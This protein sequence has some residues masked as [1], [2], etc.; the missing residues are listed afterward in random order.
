MSR[1]LVRAGEM[2]VAW[3]GM[4]SSPLRM[5]W[6]AVMGEASN[7]VKTFLVHHES[8]PGRIYRSAGQNVSG[9]ISSV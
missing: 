3:A 6:F 1:Y 2:L 7:N 5:R 4:Q 8:S 9:M